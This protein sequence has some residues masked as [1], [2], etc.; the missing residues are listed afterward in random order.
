MKRILAK[1]LAANVLQL[2][3]LA[4]PPL[5]VTAERYRTSVVPL[6]PAETL[7]PHFQKLDMFVSSSATALQNALVEAD[8]AAA[9]SGGYPYSYIEPI[10][11]K[12]YLCNRAPLL[13]NTNPAIF[14]KR[15]KNAGNT[16]VGVAAAIVHSI[17]KWVQNVLKQGVEVRNTDL[18]VSPLLRQFGAALIPG[19][20]ADEFHTTPLEKLRH[21][22][23]LHDGH[24]YAVRVFDDNQVPLERAVIQRC[25]EF[26]LSITPDADNTTSISLLTASSRQTWAGAYAELV[27]TPENAETLKKMQEGMV[28]VCL[29][30][31]KW[32]GDN[33]LVN[34]AMLHGNQEES[35]NRWY[36]K[37]QII[38]SADGQ[39]AFNFEH[40][41]SDGVQWA[42]WVGDVISGVESAD[43]GSATAAA[44]A[45]AS[46]DAARVTPLVEH[47]HVTIGKAFAGRIRSARTEALELIAN[48]ALEDVRLPFGKKQIKQLGV[49]PDAFVQMC[50]QVAFHKCRNKLAPT[51]EASSTSRFFHG[52]TETIRSATQEMLALAEAVNKETKEVA[53]VSETTQAALVG[54]VKA[55]SNR[56][57]AL[58]K[59]SVNGE[60]VDRHLTALRQL[61]VSRNDEAALNFFNDDVYKSCSTWTLSTSNMS[62]AWMDRFAFGPVT[63]NGYGL[64]Y[65]VDEQEV[66]IVLSAFNSS[67][68]TNVSDLKA[69]ITWAAT[70][71]YDVLGGPKA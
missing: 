5:E 15:L 14:V 3:R 36:D 69:A 35:E 45:A 18:D 70:C 54:L 31:K 50:Y 61:A 65:V 55:A 9:A 41:G 2:P 53:A 34:G 32:E 71:L 42:R 60:G 30:T 12:T 46:I 13:V 62:Y 37:H 56:H 27:K 17:A 26:L 49:S 19:E 25:I 68:S 21:I 52:R 43:A 24:P 67:P 11:D 28:V 16:Q 66:R 7:K 59:A 57:I 39:V 51:Y 23:V 10:W 63:H 44:T 4:I 58:V 40:S 8:K 64:G 29:D 47:L 48:T 6:K 1:D 33:K 38:V 20:T 22:I